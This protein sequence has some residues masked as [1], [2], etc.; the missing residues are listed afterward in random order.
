MSIRVRGKNPY[1]TQSGKASRNQRESVKPG[2]TVGV[3]V[4]PG[5]SSSRKLLM[6]SI[7]SLSWKISP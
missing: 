3:M 4:A 2:S 1:A 7:S 5:A 6:R